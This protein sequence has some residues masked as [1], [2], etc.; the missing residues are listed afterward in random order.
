MLIAI[1]LGASLWAPAGASALPSVTVPGLSPVLRGV[2]D[3]SASLSHSPGRLDSRSLWTE[4][5][6]V[7]GNGL[8]PA[9][10][11]QIEYVSYP[12]P[13]AEVSVP[14]GCSLAS[15]GRYVCQAGPLASGQERQ[16]PFGYR[17]RAAG[18]Y[19]AS[20]RATT[21]LLDLDGT[22]D[23]ATD[24][25][26]IVPDADVAVT[27]SA[28]AGMASGG[29]APITYTLRNNGPGIAYSPALIVSLP[30]C[31]GGCTAHFGPMPE[32]CQDAIGPA[33]C[34]LPDVPAGQSAQVTI[35]V[36]ATNPGPGAQ[37]LAVDARGQS[38]VPDPVEANDGA[39]TEISVAPAAADL[40]VSIEGPAKLV[41]GSDGNTI[42]YV[43]RNR[44]AGVA[45]GATLAIGSDV[46]GCEG[47]CAFGGWDEACNPAATSPFALDGGVLICGLGDIA[48]GAQRTL[49][50]RLFPSPWSNGYTWTSSA[51]AAS[52]SPD[53]D[54]GN[55]HA[56]YRAL[57]SGPVSLFPSVDGPSIT[58]AGAPT[59]A[60]WSVKNTSS[61]LAR[62]VDIVLTGDVA[63]LDLPAACAA[64][65][66]A[67]RCH[68]GD[69]PAG[70][71][72]SIV[73]TARFGAGDHVIDG[74]ADTTS[75][76]PGP[77]AGATW[78]VQAIFLPH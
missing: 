76:R 37:R 12:A 36:T 14:A 68:L 38:A 9:L 74:R 27:A 34:R 42:S 44:G 28:P 32:G 18:T 22:N 39:H 1:A 4:V 17:I 62:N 52:G 67:V 50:V 31:G 26:T 15:P 57:I 47:N 54:A 33:I 56:D 63:A 61:L 7:R 71:T 21:T 20:A 10:G 69:V 77:W 8:L 13:G 78:S 24:Q 60:T 55:D 64:A 6:T 66:A 2:S 45:T 70:Q 23:T 73:L 43:V 41:P 40:A 72:R 5:V 16:F 65:G 48:P 49:E 46:V 53:A 19:T 11:A 29:S 25:V 58:S 51:G 3:V 59:D 75:E 35:P 30:T